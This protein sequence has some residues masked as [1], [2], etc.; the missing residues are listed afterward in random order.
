MSSPIADGLREI[1][2]MY[3]ANPELKAPKVY[4]WICDGSGNEARKLAEFAKAMKPCKKVVNDY[5]FAVLRNYG[6]VEMRAYVDRSSVCK[7]VVKWECPKSL[8]ETLGPE[9]EKELET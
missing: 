2:D 7:K 4:L 6:P 9:F 1:A 8:L 5:N 3:E